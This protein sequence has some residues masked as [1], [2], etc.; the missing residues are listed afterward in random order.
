MVICGVS[1]WGDK[2]V[3][4]LGSGDGY[5]TL[6]IYQ[7]PLNHTLEKVDFYDIWIISQKKIGGMHVCWVLIKRFSDVENLRKS[8]LG[9]LEMSTRSLKRWSQQW[10]NRPRLPA[11]F[12]AILGQ[13]WDRPWFTW[14]VKAVLHKAE[15]PD[16]SVQPMIRSICCL[17]ILFT[18]HNTVLILEL[19]REAVHYPI[20]KDLSIQSVTGARIG[21]VATQRTEEQLAGRWRWLHTGLKAGEEPATEERGQ[22]T[23]QVRTQAGQKHRSGRENS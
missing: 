22:R 8:P 5:T 9:N 18:E 10:G 1:F 23:F 3:L 19:P 11:S 21:V 7:K 20:C 6:W 14:I 13:W 17:K 16:S 2:N 4:E 15:Q 12:Q